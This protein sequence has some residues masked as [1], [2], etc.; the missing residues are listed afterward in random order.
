LVTIRDHRDPI[1]LKEIQGNFKEHLIVFHL[2]RQEVS[3]G[4]TPRLR[5]P[6]YRTIIMERGHRLHVSIPLDTEEAEFPEEPWPKQV[7]IRITGKDLWP[8]TKAPTQGSTGD[9]STPPGPS[10]S[11][12]AAPPNSQ[13]SEGVWQNAAPSP[14]FVGDV[15]GSGLW[16]YQSTTY[17]QQSSIPDDPHALAQIESV[18]GIAEADHEVH[19]V[20]SWATRKEYEIYVGVSLPVPDA[21][22]DASHEIQYWRVTKFLPP[23]ATASELYSWPKD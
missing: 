7:D 14:S 18:R 8:K 10:G 15:D 22:L 6:Y 20:V 9:S 5:I 11:E 1:P 23:I 16:N 21:I 17:S 3:S 19:K 2:E 12:P 13:S 4:F